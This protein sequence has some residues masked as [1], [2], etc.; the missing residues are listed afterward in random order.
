MGRWPR[1]SD[2]KTQ[3]QKLANKWRS[4]PGTL[5]S[6]AKIR[7]TA[8]KAVKAKTNLCKAENS[9]NSQVIYHN[10]NP[11]ILEIKARKVRKANG[12]TATVAC[13]EALKPQDARQPQQKS[14][15][16]F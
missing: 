15:R 6:I 4:K 13:T 3:P 11:S 10:I 16:R 8:S 7:R 1:K 5:A 12:G 9:K 14:S 2:S